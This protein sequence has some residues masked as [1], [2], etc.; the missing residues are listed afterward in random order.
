VISMLGAGHH[1]ALR[2]RLLLETARLALEAQ[3]FTPIHVGPVA[4]DVVVSCPNG[5]NPADATN[6]LGGIADVLEEKS[7]R[8]E[9]SHLE[10][11]AKVWLYGNDRQIKQVS[12]R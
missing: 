6:F 10:G 3:E 7:R 4:L 5:S 8:G 11:L 1:L 2:V 12:Y 9:L